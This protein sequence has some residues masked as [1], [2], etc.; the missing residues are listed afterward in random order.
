[1]VLHSLSTIR[2]TCTILNACYQE[3]ATIVLP[4]TGEYKL[5]DNDQLVGHTTTATDKQQETN[6][7]GEL[8][9]T[10]NIIKRFHK[11]QNDVRMSGKQSMQTITVQHHLLSHSAVIKYL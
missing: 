5:E 6:D 2:Y 7:A 11:N 9:M 3:T 1:M 8:T 10:S 4:H